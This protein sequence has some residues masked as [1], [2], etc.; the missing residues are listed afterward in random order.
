MNQNSV[1][2]SQQWSAP[3]NIQMVN[4]DH[5]YIFGVRND[6][7]GR[8]FFVTICSFPLTL[9]SNQNCEKNN[10]KNHRLMCIHFDIIT[11]KQTAK[12]KDQF[13]GEKNNN[14]NEMRNDDAS[15]NKNSYFK[16]KALCN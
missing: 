5:H 4:E 6:P 2:F 1:L 10:Q 7:F 8:F 12:R 16:M 3:T 13:Q 9:F 11:T 15:K 14:E